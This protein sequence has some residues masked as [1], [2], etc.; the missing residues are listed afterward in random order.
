MFEYGIGT[1]C[2]CLQRIII[3]FPDRNPCSI[4]ISKVAHVAVS[5]VIIT[6][7]HLGE[8]LGKVEAETINFVLLCPVLQYPAYKIAG[9]EAL[10]V[11]V[12]THIKSMFGHGV[13]PGIGR[14]GTA[15]G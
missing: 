15:V 7:L 4:I 1:G 10:M 8:T 6:G 2:F 12:V 5:A 3:P 9:I 11:H 14:S 13:V